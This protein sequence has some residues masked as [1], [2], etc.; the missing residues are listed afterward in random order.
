VRLRGI[1]G[2]TLIEVLVAVLVLAVGIVGAAGVQVAA[3]RTRHATGLMSGAV[4][5]A[6]SLADRMRA[7]AAQAQG[8]DGANPYLQLRY[9]AAR[10]GRPS[11]DGVMCFSGASCSSAQL[12]VFDLHEVKLAVFNDF[13][14]GRVA[15]CRDA[16]VWAGRALAWECAGAGN[17]PIVIKLGWRDR[18]AAPDTR[19]DPSVALIVGGAP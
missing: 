16:T 7:N 11:G 14:E 13:P 1:G 4:Q 18:R 19:I 3:L 10:E 17:A 2:F 6:G 12:A 15:V 8:G 5:L 9:D